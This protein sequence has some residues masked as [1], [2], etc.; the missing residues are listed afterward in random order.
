MHVEFI[1]H[2]NKIELDNELTYYNH[3]MW[4]ITGYNKM[5]FSHIKEVYDD[6]GECPIYEFGIIVDGE[7]KCFATGEG[8]AIDEEKIGT[9]GVY[10]KVHINY[11]EYLFKPFY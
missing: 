6:V 4:K 1:I 5:P 3:M 8:E 10:F 9:G 2:A 7:M 11:A